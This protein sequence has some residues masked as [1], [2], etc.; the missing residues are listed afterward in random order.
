MQSRNSARVSHH[1]IGGGDVNRLRPPVRACGPSQARRDHTSIESMDQARHLPSCPAVPDE[2][3]P[4]DQCMNSKR[5]LL[6]Q[7]RH[8][9]CPCGRTIDEVMGMGILSWIV[10][11]W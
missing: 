9:S 5:G 2:D 10:V 7:G 6:Q 4:K 3:C 8:G 1:R 11:D